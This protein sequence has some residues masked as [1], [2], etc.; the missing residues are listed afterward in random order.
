[1]KPTKNHY[2]CPACQRMKILFNSQKEARLFLK[3]NADAIEEE[4]GIRPIRAYYCSS[5]CG[6]HITS[7]PN[8]HT[9]K[10]LIRQFGEEV[11]LKMY[12]KISELIKGGSIIGGLSRKIQLLRHSLK[13]PV[14]N[15]IKCKAMIDD[16]FNTFEVVIS[17]RLINKP[18]TDKLFDKFS[19]LCQLF[20]DKQT[21]L[22]TTK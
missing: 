18:T 14:I 1:M 7:N 13:F 11:G 17:A 12:D 8:S 6:W 2:Y 5:C 4:S 19:R 16:L 15:R 22:L 9:R 20:I 10:D 3:F 21:P